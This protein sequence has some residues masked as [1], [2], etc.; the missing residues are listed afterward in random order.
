VPPFAV[1]VEVP[2]LLLHVAGVPVIVAVIAVGWET[3]TVCV[4]EHP[5]ES[6]TV[7]E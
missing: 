1:A 4:E 2:S 7:A 5:F 3:E 6:V